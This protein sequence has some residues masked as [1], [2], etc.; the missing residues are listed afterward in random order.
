MLHEHHRMSPPIFLRVSMRTAVWIVMCREPETRAPARG[1]LSLFSS[2]Q[3]MSPGTVIQHPIVGFGET[4]DWLDISER[5]GM[6]MHPIL[7]RRPGMFDRAL[8]V[9]DLS[10]HST[11]DLRRSS[12]SCVEIKTHS[13]SQRSRSPCDRSRRARCRQPCN[14]Q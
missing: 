10:I 2:T 6:S 13:R 4:S 11:T 3:F 9:F 5:S 12:F 1:C 8:C 7:L 14:L